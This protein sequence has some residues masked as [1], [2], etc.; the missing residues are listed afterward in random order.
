MKHIYTFAIMA[1]AAVL[2]A[3]CAKENAASG[4]PEDFET[5][6]LRAYTPSYTLKTVLGD[7]TGHKSVTWS[8]GDA[9]KVYYGTSATAYA[10]APVDTGVINVRVQTSSIKT[11]Y[12]VYPSTLDARMTSAT[13]NV[14][15]PAVQDGSFSAANIM[16]A[17]AGAERELRFQN[18]ASVIL[19]EVKSPDITK[20]VVR[21][22]DATPI[23]GMVD[24]TFDK[25]TGEITK[26]APESASATPEIT[27][28]VKGA[29]KY[30]IALLPDV[31]LKAGLA[32]RFFKG[33]TPVSAVLSR[34]AL[35]SSAEELVTI[36]EIDGKLTNSGDFFVKPNGSGDG[37]SWSEAAG[38]DKLFAL[39]NSR[40]SEGDLFDGTTIGWRLGGGNVYVAQGNYRKSDGKTLALAIANASF[41]LK[42]GFYEGSTGTD[43]SKWDPEQYPTVFTADNGNS[44]FELSGGE[45][46]VMNI[47]GI[48]LADAVTDNNGAA[49]TCNAPGV[50]FFFDNCIFQDNTTSG[51]GGAF[52]IEGGSFH[53]ND[54]QFLRNQATTTIAS[55]KENSADAEEVASHGGAIFANTKN[56]KLYINRCLFKGNVAFFGADL[57]VRRGADAFIYRS[58]FI[59]C[60]AM[61]PSYFGYYYGRSINADA[62]GTNG[63]VGKICLCNCTITKTASVYSTNGGLPQLAP[64]SYFCM[65]VLNTFHDGAVANY[66]NNNRSSFSTDLNWI[67]ANLF[68]NSNNNAINLASSSKRNGYYNILDKG[69]NSY[70]TLGETDSKVALED[71]TTMK[72]D[73]EGNFYSWTLDETAHPVNK[74]TRTQIE[75][76]VVAQA[77]EFDA[78]MRT[79]C[80]DGEPYLYDQTGK[81]RNPGQI[82]P[83]AWDKGL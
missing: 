33:E 57:E 78:W 28:N 22:N 17:Y 45:N 62:M 15:I 63:A 9:V 53:F 64:T 12:A 35:H 23:A 26:T 56:V 20:V 79:L 37:S 27:L 21:S 81:Q 65:A 61:A 48:T 16:A 36:G 31:D 58:A 14:N 8:E 77:P 66:R 24:L 39:L 5:V 29:G 47:N 6:S 83:G 46:G 34:T 10:V 71:F 52:A 1:F 50:E 59:S 2:F 41:T 13:F 11:F 32:F 69:K 7:E 44:I 25:T 70:E 72:F 68:V 73:P 4:S 43:L 76:I 42:G 82:T 55:S 30:Y 38:P 80:E 40:G 75:E 49:V 18:A 74:P 51:Q 19:V 54:C 60:N 67:V 3:S